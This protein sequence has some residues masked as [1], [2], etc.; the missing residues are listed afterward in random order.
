[1]KK[2][3]LFLSCLLSTN[4]CSYNIPQFNRIHIISENACYELKTNII[5]ARL[6]IYANGN[7]YKRND[8][9]ALEKEQKCPYC[10]I[11]KDRL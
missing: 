9:I 7:R 1:M 6:Y 10:D 8:V 5:Y 3:L 4:A 2:L 11:E